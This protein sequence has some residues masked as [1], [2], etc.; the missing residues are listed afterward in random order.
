M[1]SFAVH[2]RRAEDLIVA[3]TD[4]DVALVG[5]GKS[6]VVNSAA[7]IADFMFELFGVGHWA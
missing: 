1:K 7:D 4:G 3:K 5:C 2:R 6:L